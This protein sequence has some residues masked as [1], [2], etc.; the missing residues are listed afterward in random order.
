MDLVFT[1]ATLLVIPDTD[2]VLREARRV[3]R[4]GGSLLIFDYSPW[5]ARHDA[6]HRHRFS[7]KRLSQNDS[8]GANEFRRPP[9]LPPCYGPIGKRGF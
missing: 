1:V 2:S 9:D 6:N 7:L 4:P 5:V 3:L 8:I